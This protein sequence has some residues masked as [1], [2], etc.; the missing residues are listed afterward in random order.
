MPPGCHRHRPFKHPWHTAPW[1]S[2]GHRHTAV[3][4]GPFSGH[5]PLLSAL[6]CSAVHCSAAVHA[7]K[8]SCNNS[9][10]NYLRFNMNKHLFYYCW[11]RNVSCT[12]YCIM[13]TYV[14]I[15]EV[16]PMLPEW[17]SLGLHVRW[18]EVVAARPALPEESP[19]SFGGP[20]VLGRPCT[21]AAAAT[22]ASNECS[23]KFH[24]H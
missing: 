11:L 6:Q 20:L 9:A 10:S 2:S 1:G 3:H 13:Y 4:C 15:V 23:R 12:L 24:N 17:C 8:M 18:C 19:A 14:G 21:T 7:L 22:R 16:P 5:S